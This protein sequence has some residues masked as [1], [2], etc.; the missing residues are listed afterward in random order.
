MKRLTPYSIAMVA[1]LFLLEP[2]TPGRF[3]LPADVD[4][5]ELAQLDRDARTLVGEY[6]VVRPRENVDDERR[7]HDRYLALSVAAA[8]VL[9]ASFTVVFRQ[10]VMA[11]MRRL[12]ER[13][14]ATADVARKFALRQVEQGTDAFGIVVER[15]GAVFDQQPARVV[16]VVLQEALRQAAGGDAALA[17]QDRTLLRFQL[18]LCAALLSLDASLAELTHWALRSVVG[19]RQVIALLPTLDPV[20]LQAEIVRVRARNA[21]QKWTDVDVDQELAP[22]PARSS[23]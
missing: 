15:F 12:V 17:P 23:P 7:F 1:A 9:R 20:Q 22:W 18:D 21:W 10:S 13:E 11:A 5:D 14:L 6:I 19:A 8:S 4:R 2:E 16:E 3:D